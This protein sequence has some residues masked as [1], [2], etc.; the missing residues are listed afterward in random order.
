MSPIDFL[1]YIFQAFLL[2]GSAIG[3]FDVWRCVR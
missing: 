3:V 1:V 2:Q